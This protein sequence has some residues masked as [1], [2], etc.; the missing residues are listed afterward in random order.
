MNAD[1]RVMRL[2]QLSNALDRLDEALQVPMSHTLAIDGTIKRFE[3][4]FELLWKALK[5][6]LEVEGV[7]AAGPRQVLVEA[8]NLNWVDDDQ[9]WFEIL[10]SRN[11]CAHVYDSKIA[12]GIYAQI[13]A[14]ASAIR[15]LYDRLQARR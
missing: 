15:Q 1:R 8:Y 5:D 10:G 13:P 12:E 4:V 11:M 3:F 6:A 2:E 7:V 9:L 14:F